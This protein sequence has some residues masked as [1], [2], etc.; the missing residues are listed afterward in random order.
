MAAV[1]F[2]KEE[3]DTKCWPVFEKLFHEL[4]ARYYNWLVVIEPESGD[5]FLGQ[6]DLDVLSRARKKFPEARFFAYRLND[7]PAVDHLC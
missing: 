3:L 1:K 6:A 4:G 5:Y 2:S 7:N